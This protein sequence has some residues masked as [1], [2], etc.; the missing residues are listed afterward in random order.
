MEALKLHAD[1][2]TIVGKQV[3]GLRRQNIVPG[4]IYGYSG[5]PVNVQFNNRDLEKS[6]SKAGTSTTLQIF[7]EGIEEPYFA[8]FRDVQY[9]VIKRNVIHV[10][11]QSLNVKETVRLP[12]ALT[13]IG[14]APAIELGGVL[15]PLL[16]EV[17]V[18]ALPLAL[19]P[20][21][22]VDVS[23]IT[24]IGQSISVKDLIVPEGITIL[25]DSTDVVVQVSW[26][27]EEE[28]EAEELVDELAEM[29]EVEV[30]TERDSEDD[31]EA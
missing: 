21:I 29:G 22:P 9:D 20:T 5:K 8:I 18:E 26:I 16:N 1:P 4:V 27:V 12:I 24:E 28:E 15:L 31:E 11:L 7:V 19:V 30:I 13:F 14:I 3:K 10:D 25:N 6:I 2:R 23:V 17:D